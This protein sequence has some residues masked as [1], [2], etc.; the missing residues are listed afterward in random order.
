M[1]LK[2]PPAGESISTV[3]ISEW[4]VK[5]GDSVEED[6]TVVILETD[7]INVEV[8]APTS[9][10]LSQILKGAGQEADIG[11][12]IAH[13]EAGKR[14]RSRYPS[15]SDA[16][17]VYALQSTLPMGDRNATDFAQ[18]AHLG[19]LREGAALEE[20]GYVSYRSTPPAS[21]TWQ[22]DANSNLSRTGTSVRLRR[23]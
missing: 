14:L 17:L 15:L 13:L 11:E 2:V 6:Q 18:L 7:K 21:D 10:V 1:D 5:E 9:G 8:P 16:T 4:L 12:V 23:S 20:S 19:V 3:V 22:L